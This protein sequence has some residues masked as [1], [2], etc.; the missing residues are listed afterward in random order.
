MR[1]LLCIILLATLTGCATRSPTV[2]DLTNSP[3]APRPKEVTETAPDGTTKTI[4]Y[5]FTR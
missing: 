2:V 4:T 1:A 3:R 5:D